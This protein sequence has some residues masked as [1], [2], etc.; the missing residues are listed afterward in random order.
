MSMTKWAAGGVGAGIIAR[1]L[2]EGKWSWRYWVAQAGILIL[3]VACAVL[4]VELLTTMREASEYAI[5][6]LSAVIGYL[7]PRVL[8]IIAGLTF[9]YQGFGVTIGQ[10]AGKDD[11]D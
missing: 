2:I 8:E 5:A 7:L 3:G 1:A 4:A 11:D 10:K 9:R 6:A